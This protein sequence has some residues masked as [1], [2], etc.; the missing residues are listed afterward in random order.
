MTML[1]PKPFSRPARRGHILL[2]TLAMLALLAV[3]GITAVYFAKDQ[4]ERARI[5]GSPGPLIAI[6][7]DGMGE[8][9]GFLSTLLYDAPDS[10]AGLLNGGRGHSLV[11]TMYSRVPGSTIAWSG[12]GTFG[13]NETVTVQG[14]GTPPP[15]ETFPR[16]LLVNHRLFSVQQV[17]DPEWTRNRVVTDPVG[18]SSVAGPQQ[19]IAKNAPYTYPDLKDFYLA[20]QCPLTGEIL[21]PSFHRNDPPGASPGTG[22]GFG[23]LAPNNPNWTNLQGRFRTLRPTPSVHP[24]FPPVPPNADL[25]YTGDVK[26]L[27]GAPGGNDSIWIDIGAP[28]VTGPDGKRYKPLVA[29][30]VL[31]LDGRL[32]LNVH[33]NQLNGGVHGSGSGIAPFEVSLEKALGVEGRNVVMSRGTAQNRGAAPPPPSQGKNYATRYP[34]TMQ[35]PQYAAA[36]WVGFTAAN[37][38]QIP[39]FASGNQYSTGPLYGNGYV[40]SN[41]PTTY[42]PGHPALY[43]YKEW[44]SAPGGWAGGT[45]SLPLS[46]TKILISRYAPLPATTSQLTIGAAAPTTLKGTLALTTPF[47]P[48]AA[49]PPPPGGSYRADLAH[50]NRQL[51]TTLSNDLDRPGPMGRLVNLPG[52]P[53]RPQQDPYASSG[54]PASPNPFM[55][56]GP[57]DLNRTLTDYRNDPTQPL[58]PGNIDQT[59]TLPSNAARATAERQQFAYD[60]FARLIA[61]TSMPPTDVTVTVVGTSVQVNVVAGPGSPGYLA[62]RSLAQLAVNIV[63]YIDNDDISTQFMWKPAAGAVPAEFVYGVEKP[64]LVINEAYAEFVNDPSDPINGV[65]NQPPQKPGQVRFWVELLNPGI[66]PYTNPAAGPLGDGAAQLRYPG[67]FSPYVLEIARFTRD[68]GTNLGAALTDPANVTGS[69]AV[70][71]EIR[72]VFDD[73]AVNVPVKQRVL[74]NN[75]TYNPAGNPGQG[76]M[77]VGPTL[78]TPKPDEF[79]PSG[80]ASPPPAPWAS[81]ILAA[82]P[83]GGANNFPQN[84]LAYK[85]PLPMAAASGL[86]NRPDLKR[87]VIL[88]RRLANPYMPFNAA[89]NPYVTVDVMDYV[90][91]FDALHRGSNNGTDRGPMGGMNAT[92]YTPM[93]NRKALG[94]V[95]PYAGFSFGV[96]GGGS[97]DPVHTFPNSM[98]VDQIT[99]QANAPMNTFGRHNGATVA[100][101]AGQTYVPQ[102]AGPP[103]VPANLS[104]DTL[105]AP[106]DWLTHMDRPLVNPI[107]LMQVTADKPHEL[108]QHFVTPNGANGVNKFIGTLRTYLL[109]PQPV[110]PVQPVPP[111]P[112]YTQPA[113]YQPPFNQGLPNNPYDLVYMQLYRAPDL[114]RTQPYGQQTAL[115]GRVPGKININTIS[116]IRVWRALLDDNG[117]NTFSGMVDNWWYNLGAPATSLM[118]SRTMN[119][120]TRT[121]MSGNTYYVPVPGPSVYDTGTQ[122]GDR[123][124]LPFGVSTVPLTA[125]S[126]VLAAGTGIDDTLLRRVQPQSVLPGAVPPGTPPLLSVPAANHPYQ[127]DEAIRKI[128]NSTTTVSNTFA[129]WLTVGYFEVD[130]G[131]EAAIPAGWPAG[132]PYQGT[133]GKEFYRDAPGDGRHKFFFIVDRT[134][135]G[136]D[137][138][139]IGSGSYTQVAQPIYTTVEANAPASPGT[140]T[141]LTISAAP[142]PTNAANPPVVY[143]DGVPV[144]ISA[145]TT[146]TL[147][148]GTGV[149]QEV[150]AVTGAAY[151]GNGFATVTVSQTLKNHYA[152]ENVANIVPGNPGPQPTFDVNSATYKAVVPH[153]SRLP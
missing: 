16:P 137:P 153:W 96:P 2:V 115:G 12:F 78:T 24:N 63:D 32:N 38:L 5:Q 87:H 52:L 1:R 71:P 116:D 36:P 149:N 84:A 134:Q 120:V 23:S 136:F 97:P 65:M 48:A 73:T 27:E 148:V 90:G 56:L 26:N 14:G 80:G 62:L 66:T 109:N 91:A 107:E 53:P 72:F 41:D 114:L 76:V 93:A 45:R 111:Q 20:Y 77:L 3:V 33:G 19:F 51:V 31:D 49:T 6:P 69:F 25:T 61:A 46:D 50:A 125:G 35:F 150:V 145:G 123:P 92:G 75:G 104:G 94:K 141:T 58:T 57:I 99:V 70:D 28:I 39:S 59:L 7:D 143:S 128:M 110:L 29:A 133:W 102:N 17:F 30:L 138:S 37:S 34:F 130:P 124:F 100:G 135:L 55:Y 106:F 131:S 112:I 47:P 127:Q 118:P 119:F 117:F 11:A 40:F 142:D 108:T 89:T 81:M 105:M 83:Q 151:A 129:V 42:L 126:P 139:Q 15:T 152:G 146:P 43:N 88:L 121:D 113:F 21:V 9:N 18:G 8:A 10:G 95:Q 54:P 13:Y 86:P 67:S 4:A 85:T 64:R 98:V 103:P 140:P 122:T 60:V 74:P 44:P 144:S 82:D 101:P 22:P 79:D 147:V 68:D 132:V